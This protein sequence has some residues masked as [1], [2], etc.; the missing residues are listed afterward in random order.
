MEKSGCKYVTFF[1]YKLTYEDVK[2]LSLRNI[3]IS[4]IDKYNINFEDDYYEFCT[5]NKKKNVED[6]EPNE[7]TVEEKN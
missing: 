6:I 2:Y 5:K 3:V 1:G 7:N 4:D